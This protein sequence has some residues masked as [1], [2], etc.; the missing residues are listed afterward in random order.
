MR[1]RSLPK[2]ERKDTGAFSFGRK[3]SMHFAVHSHA[4]DA[5]QP[6]QMVAEHLATKRSDV[7]ATKYTKPSHR[8][9]RTR[10]KGANFQL[11]S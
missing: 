5:T 6:P 3:G 4:V 2:L 7:L 8:R 10:T 9:V 1:L 11:N